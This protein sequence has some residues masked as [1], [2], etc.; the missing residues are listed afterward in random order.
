MS[1]GLV[2][3]P[4]GDTVFVASDTNIAAYSVA[5]GT[6]LWTRSYTFKEPTP[7]ALSGD[8]TRLFV[9]GWRP[10]RGIT[11]AAYQS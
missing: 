8:G 2:I 4:H 6:A 10:S 5:D 9:T 3:D 7:I 1:P 11:T